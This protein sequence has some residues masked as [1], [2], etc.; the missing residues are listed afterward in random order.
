MGKKRKT[1]DPTKLKGGFAGPGGPHDRSGIIIDASN[2]VLLEAASFAK[3]DDLG[4]SGGP[5]VVA[6]LLSGR[7]FRREAQAD[8]LFLMDFDGVATLLTEIYALIGR[9]GSDALALKADVEQRMDRMMKE[10][11]LDHHHH[12]HHHHHDDDE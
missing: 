10:G 4:E 2:A 5:P 6:M 12:H 8:V 3:A 9:M 7:V 11:L 1:S